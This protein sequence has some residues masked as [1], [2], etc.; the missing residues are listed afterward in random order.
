[1]H[2]AQGTGAELEG[3]RSAPPEKAV[4]H[5]SSRRRVAGLT[6]LVILLGAFGNL[7]LGWGMKHLSIA[8]GW[9]PL[10]YVEAMTSPFV[11]LGI[12]L[13][14]LWI[15]TRMVLLSRS[16]LS[17]VLPATAVGYILNAVFSVTVL[18]ESI[19]AAQWAGTLLIFAGAVLV[20]SDPRGLH[21]RR[22]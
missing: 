18:H 12:L 20:G 9:R 14:V 19:G 2:A 5:H 15:L 4:A 16:D 7:S 17:F 21:T 11:A 3:L 22:Q 10:A 8:M 1:M 6:L 13:L